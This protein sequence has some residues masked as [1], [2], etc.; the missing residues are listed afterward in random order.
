MAEGSRWSFRAGGGND[1]RKGVRWSR[2]PERGARRK[3]MFTA[4]PHT[5]GRLTRSSHSKYL[6]VPQRQSR[7]R[8]AAMNLAPRRGAGPCLRRCP[9]V[10]AP[11]NPRRPPATVWQPSGLTAPERPNSRGRRP[12][13]PSHEEKAGETPALLWGSWRRQTLY[14][15]E[16]IR[17]MKQSKLLLVVA[18]AASAFLP[19]AAGAPV[20][21]YNVAW[22]SPSANH[23]GSMP[24]GNGDITLNAWMT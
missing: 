18:L 7:A 14:S 3:E 20:D 10:A 11:K 5:V 13:C 6:A 12:A 22:D 15:T 17:L 23:H 9:E 16:F 8:L 2:T 4:W 19:A 24:L 1:H 21:A